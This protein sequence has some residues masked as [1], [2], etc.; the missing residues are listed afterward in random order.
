MWAGLLLC[1]LLYGCNQVDVACVPAENGRHVECLPSHTT[2][3]PCARQAPAD[4]STQLCHGA[5]A[6][7]GLLQHLYPGLR[8][9]AP[10]QQHRYG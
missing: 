3:S 8:S 9:Q 7:R 4:L 1:V 6:P 10:S 2:A 5:D